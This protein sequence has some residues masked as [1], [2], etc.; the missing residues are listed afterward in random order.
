[1]TTQTKSKWF[2]PIQG[3]VTN[4]LENNFTRYQCDWQDVVEKEGI[5]YERYSG[6]D[7]DNEFSAVIVT[8]TKQSNDFFVYKMIK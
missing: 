6:L 4:W 8:I 1:M 5:V 7:N 2:Y 3:K